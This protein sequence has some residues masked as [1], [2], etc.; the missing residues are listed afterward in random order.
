VARGAPDR[1]RGAGRSEGVELRIPDGVAWPIHRVAVSRRYS[2][3]L[4]V[5]ETEW[6]LADVWRA[7]AVLDA[8]EDAEQEQRKRDG[9]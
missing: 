2:D 3:S 7:N 8:I 9:R 1:G 4:H 6:S 5:I